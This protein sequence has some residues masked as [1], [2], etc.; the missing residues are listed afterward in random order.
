MMALLVASTAYA[1]TV[2]LTGTCNQNAGSNTL[3]FTLSNSGNEAGTNLTVQFT[4]LGPGYGGMENFSI[5]QIA[6]SGSA[7]LSVPLGGIGAAPGT[8][9]AY[10]LVKF[11]Q[12]TEVYNAT[13]PCLVNIGSSTSSQIYLTTN[14]IAVQPGLTRINATVANQGNTAVNVNLGLILPPSFTY[15][16]GAASSL[17]IAPH[18]S[19]STQFNVSYTLTN[20]NFGGAVA[21]YYL[22]AGEYHSTIT[23]IVLSAEPGSS[24]SSAGYNWTEIGIGGVVVLFGLLI[25]RAFYIRRYG[26]ADG[27]AATPNKQ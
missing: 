1:G 14:V 16:H 13:F 7:S 10:F 3:N 26:K 20:G 12:D 5:S 25:V 21:A 27:Q 18:S 4:I 22:A 19:N 23:S 11:H 8:L 24:S 9:P 17:T 6:P 15:N 2:T